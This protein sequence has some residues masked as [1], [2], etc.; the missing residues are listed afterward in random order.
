MFKKEKKKQKNEAKKEMSEEKSKFV[1]FRCPTKLFKDILENNENKSKTIVNALESYQSKELQDNL[2]NA[3]TQ[4]NKL[5]K[6][7][8]QHFS[9]E[10]N[11]INLNLKQLAF[12]INESI[13]N[14]EAIDSTNKTLGV[15]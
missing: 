9:P 6:Q 12:L 4:L 7:I 13:T 1:G 3:Y 10:F 5:F 11:N 2:L 14:A 15:D 8:S